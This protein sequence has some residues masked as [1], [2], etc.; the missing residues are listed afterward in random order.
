MKIAVIVA[1]RGRPQ[2]A[3]GVIECAR[4]LLSGRHEVEFIVAADADDSRTVDY[5][6]TF[7]RVTLCVRTRPI[8]VG[9]CW[10][11]A[12]KAHPADIYVA[13]PDDF[14]MGAPGWDAMMVNALTKGIEGTMLPAQLGIISFYDP[15][16]PTISALFG[17]TAKWIELNGFI[18]DPRF[19]FWFGDSA[20]VEAALFATGGGMPGSTSLHFASMPGNVNPRLRDMDLWWDLFAATRHER[21]ETGRK[22]ARH[23][24]LPVIDDY[25]MARLIMECEDRDAAGRSNMPMVLA[26]IQHPKAPDAE[27]MAAKAQAEEYLSKSSFLVSGYSPLGYTVPLAAIPGA[28]LTGIPPE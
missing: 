25:T 13:L 11:R 21:V 23:A 14:W 17:M 3:G 10:N 20:L 8:G 26:S 15:V 5:F 24:G 18:F 6:S 27:Y 2:K 4:D 1:T 16:Q 12:A 19:P 22:I 9:D 7:Q 28:S